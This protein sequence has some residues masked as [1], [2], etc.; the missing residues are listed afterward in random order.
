[1]AFPLPLQLSMRHRALLAATVAITA[2]LGMA[3]NAAAASITLAWNASSGATGYYLLY[4]T[5]SAIQTTSCPGTTTP[6]CIDVGNQTQYMVPGLTAGVTY[7]FEVEAY[8]ASGTSSPSAEVSGQA[9]ANVAPS[10][11]TSNDF[12]GD[13]SPDLIWQ[14][15]QTGVISAWFMHGAQMTGAKVFGQVADTNWKIVGR[16]D[17]DGDGFPDLIWQNVANGYVSAWYMV[18]TQM[19]RTAML[20]PSQVADTNWRIVGVADFNN[21]GKPDLLWQNGAT[22]ALSVWLMNGT[23]STKFVSVTPGQV[24]DTNWKVAG[25]GDLNNDGHPDIVWQNKVTGQLSTWFMNGTV[26]TGAAMLGPSAVTDTGWKI[27]AIVDVD[28]DGM[29]DLIWEHQSLGLLSAWLMNGTMA[30]TF[31]SLTPSVVADPSWQIAGPQ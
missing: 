10:E 3:A 28:G 1:M 6:G 29:D 30:R 13:G 22:G 4:G 25:V 7:Y 15:S 19:V 11:N 12:N 26:E 27:R 20:T 9:P 21:D 24:A 2:T 23:V 14:N 5:Q 8:N 18:G 17:L 31:I 16:A